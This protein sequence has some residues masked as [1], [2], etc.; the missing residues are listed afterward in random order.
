MELVEHDH[1]FRRVTLRR[2][3][4]WLPHIHHGK[5]DFPTILL[6]EKGIE[7]IHVGF[8]AARAAEPYCAARNKI[9]DDDAIG[10]SFLD[11]DFVNAD[12]ARLWISGH[13]QL[14]AHIDLVEIPDG[15]P[16]Q[17]HQPRHILDRHHAAQAADLH[18]EA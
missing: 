13:A 9:A 10:M 2:N 17:I 16:M 18:G 4:K 14:L 8:R 1:G 3:A 11:R 15:M 7:Q 6:A 12:D 5:P